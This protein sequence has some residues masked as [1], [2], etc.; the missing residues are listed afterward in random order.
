MVAVGGFVFAARDEPVEQAARVVRVAVGVGAGAAERVLVDG[1]VGERGGAGGAEGL[2][3]DGAGWVGDG[4]GEEG[5]RGGEVGVAGEEGH[6]C[7]FFWLLAP[8][9]VGGVRKSGGGGGIACGFYKYVE[10]NGLDAAMRL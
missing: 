7:V 9:S 6:F 5:G 4:V 3:A 1:L 8:W 10:G 2:E